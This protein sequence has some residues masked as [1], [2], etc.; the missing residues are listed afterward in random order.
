M[1]TQDLQSI[2]RNFLL[3]LREMASDD[4]GRA[5]ITFGVD[6]EFAVRASKLS[7]QQIDQLADSYPV[8]VFRPRFGIEMLDEESVKSPRFAAQML[9]NVQ[10]GGRS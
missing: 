1:N 10:E 7:I 8:I 6:R 3:V 2:N 5:C 4:I 9:A